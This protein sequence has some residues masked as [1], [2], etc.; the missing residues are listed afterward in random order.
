MK[1]SYKDFRPRILLAV[2]AIGVLIAAGSA[3]LDVIWNTYHQTLASHVISNLETM[4]R[5]AVLLQQDSVARV[6]KIADEA[7]H[8]ALVARLIGDPDDPSIHN[9]FEAWI[10]PLYQSRGFDDYSLISPDGKRVMTAGTRPYIGQLPLPSTRETL[11]RAELLLA[12]AVTPP[13][14]ANRPFS[15]LLVEN[16][17]AYAYQLSCAPVDQNG[18]RMAFLCLH[19]N[20]SVRLYRLLRDGRPGVTGEAYVVDQ[21]GN[22]LS[23]IRFEKSLARPEGAEPGW[24]LFQLRA[25]VIPKREDGLPDPAL[26]STEPLTRVVERLLQFDSFDT[27]LLSDYEDYRGRRVVGAARW[28]PDAAL[29][30]V[31]EE[32]MDEA[33][34]SYHFARR[35]LVALIALGS[36][37]ILA[38]TVIDW[39]SR[40]SLARSEQRLAAFRDH[41]P[42]GMNMKSV[43]GRYLMANPVFEASCHFPPGYVLGKTDAELFPEPEAAKLQAEHAEVLHNGRPLARNY[44]LHEA[45][46]SEKTYSAVRFPV[47][48]EKD[49]SVVAVGTVALDISE[50]IRTQRD[51]EELTQTLENKVAKRTEELAA[52]RDLAES[53]SRAKAEFLANMSH[54]IRTPLNAII[55]M[56]YLA[57]HV[58]ADP[59]VGHYISR[60]QSSSR[61]LLGI[62]NDILDLS[63]FEAG[64]LQLRPA[65]FSLRETMDE[66]ADLVSGQAQAKGLALTVEV[67]PEVPDILI[68]DVKRISQ[69]LINFANNAVKFTERGRVVLRVGECARDAAQ[70][71]LRFDVE[72]S[73]IGIADE[74]IPRLFSPFQQ[75]D[76]SISRPFEGSG[77]GLAISRMLAELMGGRVGVHSRLG[78]GS[79]FSLEVPL[80][81]GVSASL[82]MQ[83]A[84]PVDAAGEAKAPEAMG[85]LAGRS[86]LLVEDNAINQEVMHDLLEMFGARVS[87]A[88]DGRQGIRC[89]QTGSF[90][91]V[92]MD[93]H[94]PALDGFAAT[95]EIRQE[96][97]FDK[98]PI[99]ALTANAL[100]GDPER[101]LAAGM[102]DYLAKPIQP[103]LLFACLKRHLDVP[104]ARKE[105]DILLPE[106]ASG[107]SLAPGDEQA[108]SAL[109][110]IPGIDVAQAVSRMMGRRDLYVRL[111]RRLVDE[112]S[113]L[114]GR[115]DAAR[116]DGDHASVRELVHGAK[117]L[118]GMLGADDLQRR[119]VDLQRQFAGG[120]VE[121][122]EIDSFAVDLAALLARLAEALRPE[123]GSTG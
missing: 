115:L 21:E 70:I 74:N 87:V 62:V 79:V 66:V 54:E 73:G 36:I 94:M 22:I 2:L 28:L 121:E 116:Q 16:P 82:S 58:N 78:T 80:R 102:N 65:E 69:I 49:G 110:A 63:K 19:E 60:I 89:L 17:S 109:S 59:R 114:V 86:I 108:F 98:L 84:R 27:G 85:W 42:A 92:L 83:P 57:A 43:D 72:D 119:C 39:R 113:D 90:D 24:S 32:D 93:I 31:V 33:F 95:A 64:K 6:R 105:A 14:S 55:G 81:I 34:R 37:L 104:E 118:L 13:I 77:L 67:A 68:G 99:V 38:L 96:P 76:G 10:T 23:P 18:L 47:L 112:R 75:L 25:R 8:K 61:H 123:R 56:G 53:A 4:S 20:P 45:D 103:D 9:A 106:V 5:G 7:T 11:R 35:A 44:A 120:G 101:C 52:A 46:G 117:S 50:L 48:D 12:G 29:G 1:L 97:R 88:G 100:E 107:D 122:G 71:R 26:I 111:A 41:I 40:R 3:V 91:L 15:T 30:L 51:L